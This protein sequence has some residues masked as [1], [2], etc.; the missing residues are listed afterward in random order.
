MPIPWR[1][2]PDAFA[3]VLHRHGVDTDAVTDV[4][5]AWRA[6]C[7]FLHIE[8]DG[9]DPTPD[10]DA[11]GFIVQWGRYTW[12]DNRPT[13]SFTRQ[14]AI[15][16]DSDP[17]DSDWQPAY[18]Q[19]DLQM[20]FEDEP[21]LAGLDNLEIQDTG[22]TFDPIGPQRTTALAEVRN[23]MGR[24]PQLRAAWHAAPTGSTLSFVHVG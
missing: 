11:D 15:A 21:E 14:L 18:W 10:A 16:E 2:T 19:I 5:A 6:F 24:Y 3:Q 8:I 12:T 20:C 17:N 7:E 23:E 22:L 13:L 1:S 9:L 4:E